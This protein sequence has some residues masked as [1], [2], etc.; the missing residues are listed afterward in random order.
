MLE[1]CRVSVPVGLGACFCLCACLSV[2]SRLRWAQPASPSDPLG[3]A[4]FHS[5]T[6]L[7]L[8]VNATGSG[9]ANKDE[10][11]TATLDPAEGREDPGFDSYK[12]ILLYNSYFDL[13]DYNLGGYGREPF[14]KNGCAVTNCY[15]TNNR[16]LLGGSAADFDAVLFHG[17]GFEKTF[18]GF[19]F[20]KNLL[21]EYF[22]AHA[23]LKGPP[24]GS[25]TR[26]TSSSSWR[27]PWPLAALIR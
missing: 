2:V 3:P 21:R 6:D 20:G 4:R 22:F 18:V 13:P 5:K 10:S 16:S 19:F 1:K 27:V 23:G 17:T 12:K 24:R 15:A 8:Q 25:P 26:D 7:A 14:V 11:S 9:N